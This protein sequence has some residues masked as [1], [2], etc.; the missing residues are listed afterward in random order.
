MNTRTAHER[1]AGTLIWEKTQGTRPLKPTGIFAL[2][3]DTILN[4]IQ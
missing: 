3:E 1:L 4:E 2:R